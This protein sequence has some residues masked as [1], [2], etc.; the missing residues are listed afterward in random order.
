VERAAETIAL[1]HPLQL[2]DAGAT[3]QFSDNV[4]ALTPSATLAITARAKQMRA[5]GRSIVDLSAGEPSFPT[6]EV[7][8]EGAAAAVRAGRTGYPPT[9]GVPE[10]REG[11]VHYLDQTS[12]FAPHD[13]TGVLVSAGVKQGLFNL[14]FCLFGDGDEVLVPAP[15]WT[16][17]LAVVE[18]ARA[19]PV[20]VQTEFADGFAL[21]VDRLEAQRTENTR[22]LLLNS[23]S[24]PSGS[25]TD[26][27]TLESICAWAGDHGIW[28][29]SDEI[30][31]RLY[32]DGE[33]A[34]SVFDVKDRPDHVVALDGMSKAFSMPGWRIGW[35]VGPP[36]LIRKASALQ[37]QTTSAAAGP[38]QYAAAAALAS[39]GREAIIGEFR[40][41]LDRRRRAAH[42]ALQGIP[43]FNAP[44]PP[45]AIYM[46]GRLGADDRTDRDSASV[47]ESLLVE[48]GVATVPGEAFGTPGF[49]RLNF[50]VDDEIFAEGAD[51]IRGW[52]DPT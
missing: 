26:L 47:A 50:S 39:E 12:S 48:T 21:S 11:I 49:L 9:P 43:G 32:F 30:Y 4:A 24:N 17:Y 35:S 25:V 33:S 7:A 51:R 41:I 28:I 23:P 22:G 52:F 14:C 37:S 31:R 20:V 6:P 16:S 1:S 13:P 27:H 45:G 34:P 18:L 15:Y 3:V 38:S 44:L 42:V 29:L 8:A 19:R 36:E 40:R 2:T 10:L 5:E 46:Y